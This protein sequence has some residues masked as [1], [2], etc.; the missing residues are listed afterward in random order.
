[1]S[2]LIGCSSGGIVVLFATRFWP[3]GDRV[4]NLSKVVNGSIAGRLRLELVTISNKQN[5]KFY[6]HAIV[7]WAGWLGSFEFEKIYNK[8]SLDW[9]MNI[10]PKIPVNYRAIRRNYV[11]S[12]W[13]TRETGDIYRQSYIFSLLTKSRPLVI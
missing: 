13:N 2:T 9:L 4:W 1:M 10:S 7:D 3:S 8:F 11:A 12:A 5:L 6:Y